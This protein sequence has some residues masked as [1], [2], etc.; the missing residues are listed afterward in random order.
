[1]VFLEKLK[2]TLNSKTGILGIAALVAACSGVTAWDMM[3]SAD[4][5]DSAENSTTEIRLGDLNG[6]NEVNASDAAMVLTAAA[7]VG[8]GD[9]SGLTEEQELAADLNKDGGFN[10]VDAAQILTY[11]AYRGS[12]G[13]ADLDTFLS[14]K[15]E[16]EE[17]TTVPST[18]VTET[19][20]TMTTTTTTTQA[21]ISGYVLND[22][23]TN[24]DAFRHFAAKY[25]YD[26]LRGNGIQLLEGVTYGSKDAPVML[27]ILNYGYIN[28][29]VIKEVFQDYTQAEVRQ[30]IRMYYSTAS[31]EEMVGT[32]VD[33]AK[34]TLNKTLGAD[35]NE[36]DTAYRNGQI[37]AFTYDIMVNC[38]IKQ[39]Y[40]T[41][42][43]Y[44]GMLA[45]YNKE[46][47]ISGET[48]DYQCMDEFGKYICNVALGKEYIR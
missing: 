20:T 37:D 23:T 36:I 19:T 45:S 22:I 39:E 42:P 14:G 41:S 4:T 38:N 13:T 33:F 27:A 24:A 21:P 10:A 31:L 7:S 2:A 48:V 28:D 30:G 29:E 1:M 12:G 35:L 40:M 25:N 44:L 46:K 32:H 8:A 15:H 9:V 43:A 11:A 17:S 16:E 18:S 3:A 26:L 47:L 5:I 6:D 34:Y